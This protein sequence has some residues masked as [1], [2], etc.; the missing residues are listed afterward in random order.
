MST[1]TKDLGESFLLGGD[2][3]G[4][5]DED[6]DSD[7]LLADELRGMY[8]NRL[9][10]MEEIGEKREEAHRHQ[11]Q[12]LQ[13]YVNELSDQNEILVQTVEELEREANDRVALM[14][15]KLQ[16]T[17]LSL[18]DYTSRASELDVH[19]EKLSKEKKDY[20]EEIKALK[21]ELNITTQQ[22][23]HLETR[24]E[25]LDYDI[26]NLVNLIGTARAT[27]KWE[28]AGLDLRTVSLDS[29]LGAHAAA[30]KE[31]REGE[32]RLTE[33]IQELKKQLA[34][35]DQMIQRL[36]KDLK[37][38]EQSNLELVDS[39]AHGYEKVGSFAGDA[40]SFDTY[41]EECSGSMT[42]KDVLI[43]KLKN[44]LE[45]SRKQ[46]QSTA[47]ELRECELSIARLQ[48]Q[49][50]K[51]Q[52]E[53]ALK[54]SDVAAKDQSLR[55]LE[56][57]QVGSKV[58]VARLEE[59][60]RE[61][62]TQVQALKDSEGGIP[63]DLSREFEQRVKR[64]EAELEVAEDQR[65]KAAQEV[66][67]LQSQLSESQHA[68]KGHKEVLVSELTSRDSELDNMK[69][70]Y[71]AAIKEI[72]QYEKEIRELKSQLDNCTYELEKNKFHIQQLEGDVVKCR[73]QVARSEEESR[74]AQREIKR[75][76]VASNDQRDALAN[77]V[78]E[79]HDTILTLKT[80]LSALD[81]KHREAVAQLSH[82]N[83]VISKLRTQNKE[84]TDSIEDY[85][86]KQAELESKLNVANKRLSDLENR[87][88]RSQKSSLEK[89]DHLGK[90]VDDKDIELRELKMAL[91]NLKDQHEQAQSKVSHREEAL[92]R[93]QVQQN[94]FVDEVSRREK[95]IQKLELELLTAQENHRRALDDITRRDDTIQQ[96]EGDLEG[97]RKQLKDAIEEKGRLEAKIQAYKISTQS[98]QDVLAEEVAKREEAIH[99]LKIEKLSLQEQQQ[100]AE[101]NVREHERAVERLRQQYEDCLQD[102]QQRNTAVVDMEAKLNDMKSKSEEYTDKLEHYEDTIR[103]LNLKMTSLQGDRDQREHEAEMKEDTIQHLASEMDELQEQHR[104]VLS[105][106]SKRDEMI[107]RLKSET[108]YLKDQQ[109][110]KEREIS[111]QLDVISRLERDLNESSRE[112]E[113]LKEKTAD[114]VSV[115]GE[116]FLNNNSITNNNTDS[117]LPQ[118]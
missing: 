54:R 97:S 116:L 16:R 51:L 18:K 113:N 67:K 71:N 111:Q 7:S 46:Q 77:E 45:H 88:E 39:N 118:E 32:K 43:R 72:Q 84:M 12:S 28:L 78:A 20:V 87:L 17:T 49:I 55:V 13:S 44:D 74:A 9:K 107:D 117:Y 86:R 35:R 57:Q 27:G 36:Q 104:D 15:N 38:K 102:M 19:V 95:A 115:E 100:K 37:G 80:E 50:G 26:D 14:E 2:L 8:R 96:L 33:H 91:S 47:R 53:Q 42:Q 34:A 89:S 79:R 69:D 11:L 110:D 3:L 70:R 81:N 6:S 105:K 22:L 109:R 10:D 59:E 101:D 90:M 60:N 4:E 5:L 66:I 40:K 76:Q 106:M 68:A 58:K 64:L 1:K 21:E 48:G 98:E 93:L 99:K 62:K 30:S 52:D 24:H 31:L 85:S 65:R 112:L 56:Q 63:L 103:E 82:R 114:D 73:E 108:S 92:Q 75:L 29:I 94:D 25:D 61:L 83:N 41:T 23:A